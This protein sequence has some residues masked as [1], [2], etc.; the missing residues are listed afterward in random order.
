MTTQERIQ[1]L[2]RLG[3]KLNEALS[4]SGLSDIDY[5][6]RQTLNTAFLLNPWFDVEMCRKALAAFLP[7]LEKESLKTWLEAYTLR[8]TKEKKIGIV[9]AGNIPAVGFHDLLCVLASGHHAHVKYSSS[10]S[11]LIPW[12]FKQLVDINDRWQ[13]CLSI[14]ETKISGAEAFIATGSDNSSRYFEYY[15]RDK[16]HLIRKN[17]TSAAILQG[18]EDLDFL[19]KLGEDIFTFYGM[20]CRSVSKLYVPAGYD[21]K[22]FF[23]AIFPY[24]SVTANRRYL[25]NYEYY[26]AYYLMNL[27]PVIDNHFLLLRPD[28]GLFSPPSVLYYEE[29]HSLSM[30]REKLEEKKTQLQCLI[31]DSRNFPEALSPSSAQLPGLKDYADGVDTMKF[32]CALSE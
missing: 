15:F 32:L 1:D 8:E 19:R 13:S 9:M 27:E 11:V 16:P 24:S 6:L 5:G 14:A 18:N 2:H 25:N 12:L 30:L 17:R 23:E 3:E 4:A 29:Y 22:S 7:W 21:F 26:R 20:G 28:S 10:D 31:A